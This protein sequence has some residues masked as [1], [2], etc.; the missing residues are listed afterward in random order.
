[1]T[2]KDITPN[3]FGRLFLKYR[4]KFISIARSYTRDEVVAEDIVAESFTNFWDNREKIELQTLPEAYI[5][6]AVKNRCL[7]W[8]RDRATKMR[9]ERNMQ[10]N[11][12]R[13]MMTEINVLDSTDMGLIFRSD[14]ERI[15]RKRFESLP[16]MTRNI[17][18]ASR[19]DDMTYREIAEKYGISERKVK[20]DIQN[21]LSVM[22]HSLKDY[23]PS[24]AVFFSALGFWQ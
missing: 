18:L 10:D 12:C 16:E 13:A 8:L 23:L 24:L 19:L 11:A 7:N 22:R 14:I 15:F 1:M 2:A 3:E 21:V 4:E 6:Q 17:F 5:L 20:R 9:I